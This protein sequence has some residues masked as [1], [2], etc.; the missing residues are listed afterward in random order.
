MIDAALVVV[1]IVALV[2]VSSLLLPSRRRAAQMINEGITSA[3]DALVNHN[4]EFAITQALE[5]RAKYGKLMELTN[6]N[7]KHD[8]ACYIRTVNIKGTAQQQADLNQALDSFLSK[9][10][11]STTAGNVAV[12][13]SGTQ[14]ATTNSTVMRSGDADNDADEV[15]LEDF[16]TNS[17]SETYENLYPQPRS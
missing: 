13:N 5:D 8:L 16:V 17:S 12:N 15:S 11:I 7:N 3:C 10:G 1:I 9:R 2:Y 14:V 6:T 4:D